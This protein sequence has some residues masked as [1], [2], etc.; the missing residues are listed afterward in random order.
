MIPFYVMSFAF[1]LGMLCLAYGLYRARAVQ[2]WMAVLP[3][4]GAMLLAIGFPTASELVC[5][6][7][8]GVP[9]S[10]ASARSGRMVL[11]E[12]DEA[13]EHTPEYEGFRPSG[14][15]EVAPRSGRR[16][17]AARVRQHG[18]PYRGARALAVRVVA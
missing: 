3:G 9:A 13:W 15:D 17:P 11:R 14:G 5:D 2:S 12:S 10:S 8:R 4:I 1:T 16:K 18:R 7:R 6:R